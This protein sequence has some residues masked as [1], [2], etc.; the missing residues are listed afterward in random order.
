MSAKVVAVLV[1]AVFAVL[2][3]AVV[4][5]LLSP[6]FWLFKLVLGGLFGALA[7]QVRPRPVPLPPGTALERAQAPRLFAL[8]D[9]VAAAV[10]G[11]S[12]RRVVVDTSSRASSGRAGGGTYVSFGLPLWAAA[13]PEARVA[14]LAEQLGRLASGAS[15]VDPLVVSASQS[16]ADWQYFFTPSGSARQRAMDDVLD[17][18]LMVAMSARADVAQSR[19]LELLLALLLLPLYLSVTLLRRQLRR[20]AGR[21]LQAGLDR[22]RAAAAQVVGDQAGTVLSR[23]S[24]LAQTAQVQMET[25]SRRDPK[26]ALWEIGLEQRLA[27]VDAPLL[28]TADSDAIDEELRPLLRRTEQDLREAARA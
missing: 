26:A 14:T 17:K 12:P 9:E 3:L 23:T 5:L 15:I 7:W 20:L 25:A 4:A 24:A 16:L 11:T 13:G 22:G 19:L 2:V 21:D 6:V 8:L 27:P 18:D 1:H 10:G 28:T